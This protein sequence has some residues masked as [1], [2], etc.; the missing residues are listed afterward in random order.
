MPAFPRSSFRAAP[1]RRTAALI[2]ISAFV[3]GSVDA[4]PDDVV[5]RY[6]FATSTVG[7]GN[8]HSWAEVSGTS[9]G[10][11]AAADAVCRARASAAN[12]ANPGDYVAWMSD[13]ENDAYC[14]V[15]G[16]TG[17]KASHCGLPALPVGAGPWLRVDGVPFAGSIEAALADNVVY[18]TL[19]VDESGNA[20]LGSLESFTATDIDGAF[21]AAFAA[22]AD[23]AHWTSA[24]STTSTPG[25]G[26]NVSSGGHWTFDGH[27]AS[28]GNL[29]HL[30]CMQKGNGLPL[31]GH[32]SFGHREAF[33][34]SADI[35]G[36]LG[37]I[38]GADAMCRSAAT[39]A[40]LYRP[41]SFK[42]LLAASASGANVVDRFEHG[43]PWYR[44]DGLVFA[45]DKAELT[46]GVVTL[47]LNV[48]ETGGYTGIAVALTGAREDGLP[49]GHDCGDWGQASGDSLAS[50][51]LANSIA[52]FANGHDWLDPAQTACFAPLQPGDWPRKLFCLSDADVIFHDEFV[53]H[54]ASP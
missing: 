54:P 35:T 13:R 28:C 27:G 10:G 50:G 12:L 29:H 25:M 14:R 2:A 1:M 46:S 52:F 32:A 51:A 16:L 45:H 7:T 42:A 30:T 24:M 33:V 31:A 4:A 6:A 43:G 41:D 11:L 37:G 15:F 22:D 18:S 44:R 53:A 19:D 5:P 26:S 38:D 49:S 47:P 20:L 23:C 36:D 39:D 8:L 3:C 17:K 40:N 48:T 9:L 34:T 21:N